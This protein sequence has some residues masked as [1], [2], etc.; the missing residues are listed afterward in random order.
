MSLDFLDSAIAR[1]LAEQALFDE[2]LDSMEGMADLLVNSFGWSELSSDLSEDELYDALNALVENFP[3]PE[4]SLFQLDF[5]SVSPG[6]LLTGS[7][8]QFY[9]D[10][11]GYGSSVDATDILVSYLSDVESSGAQRYQLYSGDSPAD[12]QYFFESILKQPALIF[13][14]TFFPQYTKGVPSPTTRAAR[15]RSLNAVC[16]DIDP[17]PSASGEHRPM[18]VDVLEHF[19]SECPDDLLPGYICLTGNGIHLWYIFD[20]PV[21]V[22]S[23]SSLRVRKLNALA[24]GLYRC[25]EL[26]LEGSDSQLDSS[27]CVLNHGF[28]APG[29]RTKYGDVVRCFCLEE[30]VYRRCSVSASALSRVVAGYLGS[31]FSSSEVLLDSDAEWK[32]RK[33]ITEEHEAW[34]KEKMSTP[35]TEAQLMMLSD[36]EGQGLLR[37]V[38]SESLATID[39]LRASELIRKALSRRVDAKLS[40]TTS[41]YSSWRTK[42]HSLIA[43]STGGVYKTVLNVMTEVAVGRRY[44]SLHMLAGVAYMMIQPGVSKAQVREDYMELLSTPWAQAGTPLTERDINN[45][46]GGYNPNNRQT[47]NSIITTLGFSPFKPP[48]KRNHRKQ[49]EHLSLVAEKKVDSSRA[50]IVNALAQDPEATMAKVCR[51]TG[52]SRPTVKK[53]WE[54]C[55]EIISEFSE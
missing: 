50:K 47:V 6:F 40:S 16:V 22:F 29:S 15:Q 12:I 3:S 46:L 53:H 37:K 38:E 42:P 48:A 39:T 4:T 9:F 25:I 14:G 19:L 21:Q 41:S 23:R 44:N 7:C 8:L 36:L 55:K 43:G 1:D 5:S 20:S 54:A 10:L 28:R 32:S 18:S 35:A 17:V 34:L 27:C 2:H 31:E 26:V 51:M 13:Q 33:Q 24:R 52:L 45:A 11:Y 30:N 49:A